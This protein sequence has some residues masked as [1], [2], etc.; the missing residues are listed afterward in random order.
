MKNCGNDIVSPGI[1]CIAAARFIAARFSA[2]LSLLAVLCILLLTTVKSQAQTT[3]ADVVGAVTDSSG[4]VLP[5]AKVTVENLATHGTH[6]A[7]TTSSGDY[8]VPFLLP[9]HYSVR[10]ELANFKTFSV[11]DITLQV[12][13]RARVDAQ[14]QVGDSSQTV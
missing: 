8:A 14:L 2:T 7:Q 5:D 11:V 4:A 3:T 12:G 9:G 6:T 10:V 1:E 13:D